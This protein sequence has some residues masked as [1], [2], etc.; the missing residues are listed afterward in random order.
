MSAATILLGMHSLIRWLVALLAIIVVVKYAIGWATNAEYKPI[1]RTLKNAFVNFFFLQVV[2]GFLLLA[3]DWNSDALSYRLEHIVTMLVAVFVA[4][5]GARWNKISD[6]KLKFRN[7]LL[8]I[9]GAFVLIFIGVWR[10]PQ[11]W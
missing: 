6:D 1:D 4:A 11:G 7:N 5:Q 2:L 10:L 9:L 8:V 3:V